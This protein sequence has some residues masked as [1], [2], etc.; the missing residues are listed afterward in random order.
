MQLNIYILPLV[1]QVGRLWHKT[2]Y[3]NDIYGYSLLKHFL[4]NQLGVKTQPNY[5]H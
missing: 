5:C 2:D 3:I 4:R 1:S